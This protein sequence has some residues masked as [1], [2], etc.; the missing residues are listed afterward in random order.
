MLSMVLR[1]EW[2]LWDTFTPARSSHLF[3]VSH[4]Y[5][6]IQVGCPPS[7][8]I[9][10]LYLSRIEIPS[11]SVHVKTHRVH[12]D[13]TRSSGTRYAGTNWDRSVCSICRGTFPRWSPH[14]SWITATSRTIYAPSSTTTNLSIYIY[15]VEPASMIEL[16]LYIY[17]RC[18]LDMVTKD[19]IW[20][21]Y[22][23][24]SGSA[25]LMMIPPSE[26]PM[27]DNLWCVWV[28]YIPKTASLAPLGDELF[29]LNGEVPT[30]IRDVSIRLFLIRSGA[31]IKRLRVHE[32]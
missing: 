7:S 18:G 11:T 2:M 30:H 19:N 28:E 26:C 12:I 29:D 17:P 3:C 4:S 22:S 9:S 32:R 16:E 8:H 20:F 5:A 1:Y 27:N 13:L 24:R 10:Y 6:N 25:A 23:C 14:P 31:Q 15:M 21:W